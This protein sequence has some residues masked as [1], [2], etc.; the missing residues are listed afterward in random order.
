MIKVAYKENYSHSLWENH[1]FPMEKY[2]LLWRQILHQGIIE[3]D[4]YFEPQAI[5][6]EDILLCHSSEYWNK[7]NQLQLSDKEV[8]KIG[9][10]LSRDLVNRE[11][12]I[13]GGT[14]DLSLWALENSCGLNIAGGTHH[15]FSDHGEGYCLLNDHAIAIRALQRRQLIKRALIV[16]LDVHQGNGSAQIFAND[17]SVFTLSI[18]GARNYPTKKEKSDLDIALAD[19]VED[20]EYMDVL[21]KTLPKLIE[22]EKPDIIF[23]LAGA[24]VLAG[25]RFGRLGLSMQG[26]YQRDEYV[27][28]TCQKLQIPVVVT[29]G[30]GYSK[31]LARIIDAHSQTFYLSSQLFD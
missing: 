28:S 11:L 17:A 9:F 24:D 1:P 8:K 29:M 26:A 4:Q 31:S 14:L 6:E 7:L 13:T 18:H 23:Y 10:P 19:G 5:S 30:G 2:E 3:K 25:D 12:D 21:Q 27:L 16:D 15:A 20:A 22:A